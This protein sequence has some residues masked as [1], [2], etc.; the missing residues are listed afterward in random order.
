MIILKMLMMHLLKKLLK[1]MLGEKVNNLFK[2][3]KT[4]NNN[5]DLIKKTHKE[6][7][8]TIETI[9]TIEIIEITET[10]EIIKTVNSTEELIINHRFHL[11]MPLKKNQ[12]LK[13][14]LVKIKLFKPK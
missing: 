6:I 2:K 4:S 13:L 7:I 3:N 12:D 11:L 10:T 14:S 1:L 9:E 8:E 5:Q